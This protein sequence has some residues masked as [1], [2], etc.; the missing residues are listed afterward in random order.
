MK[1]S[2]IILISSAMLLAS[3]SNEPDAPHKD[4][5]YALPALISDG[6]VLQRDT[7]LNIWGFA[8]EGSQVTVSLNGS[9]ASGVTDSTG[10]WRVTLPK[11]DAGGPYDLAIKYN[12]PH[13]VDSLWYNYA[14]T[15]RD[16]MI[17]EVW[18]CSGQSNMELPIRRVYWKY[19]GVIENSAN[20]NIRYYQVTKTPYFKNPLDTLIG[21]PKWQKACPENIR[22]FSAIAYFYAK[23]LHEKLNVPVGMIVSAVGGSPAEAW[24][25]EERLKEF[26]PYYDDLQRCKD[27]NYV[28][29]IKKADREA[30]QKWYDNYQNIDLG[31]QEDWKNPD[32][33]LKKWK[34][35]NVPCRIADT[36]IKFKSGVVWFERKIKVTAEQAAKKAML[37]MGVIVDSDIIY[38][39]GTQVG[40]TGYQYPPR[41]YDIPDGVLHEGENTIAVRMISNGSNGGFV[42]DKD[43]IIDFSGDTLDISGKW[44]FKLGAEGVPPKETTF[45]QYK[46]AGL[47]NA[48]IAPLLGYNFKGMIWYQ[49]ESNVERYEEYYFL[50]QTLISD[51]RNR[52]GFDFPVMIVQLPLFL[53]QEKDPSNGGW[54]NMREIQKRIADDTPNTYCVCTIDLGEWNDIHPL[55][56]QPVA[57]RISLMAQKNVYGKNLV[58]Q[59]PVA[60]N[61]SVFGNTVSITFD[62]IGGGLVSRDNKPL[63][64]FALCGED[65]K[66]FWADAV[67][68][69]NEVKVS[70]KKVKN[71]IAVR[72]AWADNPGNLNFYNKDGLPAMPFS[73]VE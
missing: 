52:F 3:C 48:M 54:A 5:K 60:N 69:G 16:V 58:A 21:S 15:V 37:I 55:A 22:E 28:N 14:D 11:Q 40:T 6:M 1:A 68:S 71:P 41:R 30:E 23:D 35:V 10:K 32:T 12:R 43:Y 29:N 7:E 26:K 56:K 67:I 73:M 49:G 17:G 50:M 4:P 47:Y 72:Y 19:P 59:G 34:T 8:T 24:I 45:F 18:L 64:G 33:D 53:E 39:N 63:R 2:S 31:V 65:G 13:K 36:K 61:V 9:A 27:D 44:S 46:P 42:A 66:Y 62:N 20:D 51:W 25:S 57:E 38:I 70:S